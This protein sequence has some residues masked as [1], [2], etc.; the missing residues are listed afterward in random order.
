MAQAA[1]SGEA[2]AQA[3]GEQP[4]DAAVHTRAQDPP[5]DISEQVLGQLTVCFKTEIEAELSS[6]SL[7]SMALHLAW[8]AEL[9]GSTPTAALMQTPDHAVPFCRLNR[10]CHSRQQQLTLSPQLL[11]QQAA[12]VD[13]SWTPRPRCS[14]LSSTSSS[15]PL[16]SRMSPNTCYLL[17]STAAL[18]EL[19]AGGQWYPSEPLK[20]LPKCS[21]QE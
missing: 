8:W 1:A 21:S 9:A 12:P 15:R 17:G 6:F 5:Q 18:G 14:Q 2:A 20:S 16:Q 7:W 4:E 3:V 10:T 13:Q 11:L 19:E